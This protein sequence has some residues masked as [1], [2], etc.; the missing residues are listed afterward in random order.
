M[1]VKL[2]DFFRLTLNKENQHLT[3]LKKEL[4]F[5]QLYFEIEKIRFGEKLHFEL[6]IPDSLENISVPHL[7][8]QP[9]LENAI[10][11]GVQESIQKVEITLSCSQSEDSV[12]LILKNHF[13]KEQNVKGEGIGLQNVRERLN[14]IYGRTDLLHT[15][16][17]KKKNEFTVTIRLPG[18]YPENAGI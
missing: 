10:K 12:F 13:E 1:I 7:I 5:T 6:E 2:S 17:D 11:H 8:L 18:K 3:T 16:I 9:I 14:L 4:N 15:E